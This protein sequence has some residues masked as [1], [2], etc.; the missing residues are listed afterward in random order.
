MINLIPPVAK[1]IVKKEYW[2]R[3]ATILA[4]SLSLAF[5]GVVALL[6]PTY[7][8]VTSLNQ[9]LVSQ[10]DSAQ[11]EYETFT[12]LNRE[13]VAQNNFLNSMASETPSSPNFSEQ[14]DLLDRLGAG[15]VVVTQYDFVTEKDVEAKTSNRII[16]IIGEARERS[17]LIQFK[18]SLEAHEQFTSVELPISN[19][20]KEKDITFSMTLTLSN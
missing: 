8:L 13:T 2:L 15:I 5:F 16:E 19:L 17:G 14:I 10:F 1:K 4:L 20:A 6:T 11:A 7:V 3:V 18:E 12:T 9:A